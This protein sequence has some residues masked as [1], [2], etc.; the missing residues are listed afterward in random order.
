MNNPIKIIY[1]VKNLQNEYQYNNYIYIGKIDNNI[2]NILEKIKNI[3]L[4]KTL[5]ILSKT[6]YIILENY[7][8]KKWY[9]KLFN[10]KHI[11]KTIDIIN[12]TKSKY[13][14]LLSIYKNEWMN[15]HIVLNIDDNYKVMYNFTDIYNKYLEKKL[16]IKKLEEASI[17]YSI[18]KGGNIKEIITDIVEEVDTDENI[19][20]DTNK[21]ILIE[22]DN[23]LDTV[24]DIDNEFS[25]DEL[26]KMNKDVES[27]DKNLKQ[28]TKIINNI[29]D[30]KHVKTNL[31]PFDTSK[32]E[33][34]YEIKLE[35]VFNKIYVYDQYL[36]YDDTIDVIKKK[37]TCSIG[38]NPIFYNNKTYP[39]LPSNI[40][41]YSVYSHIHPNNKKLL[42]DSIMIGQ[43]WIK[44]T[45]VLSIDVVPEK[46]IRRYEQL[47]K[48]LVLLKEDIKRYGSK[49][50]RED[51]ST[52][53]LRY[54]NE[55]IN[56]NEIYMLDIFNELGKNFVVTQDN[57]QNIIDVYVKIYFFNINKE[58][59]NNI[60]LFINNNNPNN[61]EF[62]NKL[63]LSYVNQLRLD[64]NIMNTIG[65]L[66]EKKKYD[67]YSNPN[68]ITQATIHLNIY[69]EK[70]KNNK[71]NLFRI[72][73][74][75]ELSNKY[76]FLIYQSIDGNLNYKI[77][78][79]INEKNEEKIKR[80]W[81][82]TS[83]YGI[84]FKIK[85]DDLDDKYISVNLNEFGRIE[86]KN[87]WQE[88]NKTTIDDLEKT[89]IY[90]IKVIKKI[91]NENIFIK[92]N[93]PKNK[94]FKF[95]FI[96]SIQKFK[97]SNNKIINHNQLS[98]LSRYFYPYFSLVIEPKKRQ[99]KVISE[100]IT[101]KYGTYLRYKR[102]DKFDNETKIEFKII[103]F[104]K[105]YEYTNKSL[106]ETISKIFNITIEIANRKIEEVQKK[107]PFIKK[108]RKILKSLDN[109]PKYKPPGIGID[110]QG[111][112][113]DNYKIRINGA[114]DKEQL[115]RINNIVNILIY[116]YNEI[117]ILKNEKYIETIKSKL[118]SYSN[119][120]NRLNKVIDIVPYLSKI[121]DVKN[122]I[123]LDKER[124]GFK[125]EKGQ[126]QWTRSC[127]NSGEN[128]KRRP[129]Q[130]NSN[131]IA[132]M[133]KDGYKLN[134]KNGYYEK[135]VK[136]QNKTITLKAVKIPNFDG[137]GNNIYYSCDPKKNK[138]HYYI[139]FLARSS[140]P[141]GHC[142]PC[143]F[144]KDQF[145]SKNKE[146]KNYYLECIG[147]GK[148]EKEKVEK[149]EYQV[150]KLY[151]IQESNKI[152]EGRFGYLPKVLNI[153]FNI[154]QQNKKVVSNNYL[155]ES[156][157][158]YYFKYGTNQIN[159][160]FLIAI[161]NLF[162]LTLSELIE[163]IIK[164][165][166][167][168]KNLLVFKSL[169]NGDI[170]IMFKNINDYIGYI[171]NNNYISY[172]L[173]IDLLCSENILSEEGINIFIFERI[174]KNIKINGT[175][176]IK[177]DYTINCN[178]IEN[179]KSY[180]K[181]N[182]K[183]YLLIK[184]NKN[185]Y[186]IKLVKIIKSKIEI[187]NNFIYDE[188]KNN[189]INKIFKYYKLNCL[190][191]NIILKNLNYDYNSKNIFNN[192]I[193]INNLK[194]IYQ[195]LDNLNKC[196]YFILNNN[197]ILLIEKLSGS[198]N[199]IPI[200]KKLDKYKKSLN[201]SLENY[202]L[203]NK[204]L[205]ID[206]MPKYLY[207][208]EIQNKKYNIIG[209][210]IFLQENNI[211]EIIEE[212]LTRDSINKLINKLGIKKI[213]LKK[214]KKI[215]ELEE[216]L[217]SK[218]KDI[219]YDDRIKDTI[220]RNYNEESYNIFKLEI[221]EY[222][223]NNNNIK[224]KIKDFI[225][226]KSKKIIL[227]IKK[228][229]YDIIKKLYI[230]K[231]NSNKLTYNKLNN[232]RNICSNYSKNN[233]SNNIF[234]DYN[235][236]KCKPILKKDLLY[237][238]ISK[239]SNELVYNTIIYNEVLNIDNYYISTIINTNIYQEKENQKIIKTSNI[240]N[241]N[242]IL[243]TIFKDNNLPKLTKTNKY[244]VEIE[245][246][247][248]Y[249]LEKFNKYYLQEIIS[250]SNSIYRAVINAYYWIGNNLYNIEDKNLGYYSKIQTSLTNYFKGL[251]INWLLD[252]KNKDIYDKNLKSY[253][254][255]DYDNIYS[256]IYNISSI[257]NTTSDNIVTLFILNQ[258]I[259][260]PIII[261]NN[262]FKIIY[263]FDSEIKNVNGDN[264]K[265]YN[266]NKDY[267]SV[268]YEYSDRTYPN[269][270][271]TIHFI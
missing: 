45:S 137:K 148:K 182:K 111:K 202:I 162:K 186:P 114:R 221:S 222:L 135:I 158:G 255:I 16:K 195:Y 251:V 190:S 253:L 31:I 21:E 26:D 232:Y 257:E 167:K 108:S 53:T 242:Q 231:D 219:I 80:N 11:N 268:L 164:K 188:N 32:N 109:I 116:I 35:D 37:I 224:D 81:F 83:P 127:Q 154:L 191:N 267:I 122:M 223:N 236:G 12:Q 177:I 38:L 105:N 193:K 23:L 42:N 52:N 247:D 133:I 235:N 181:K 168:D 269:I 113:I 228:I 163:I 241:I 238:F 153:F 30:I 151:I 101:S 160:N 13:N 246:L 142:M 64:N 94:D 140:N 131:N 213:E 20:E 187:I 46:N 47:Y 86:Y 200:I 104:M 237:N 220:I 254:N 34:H 56:N 39:I 244:D 51:D 174:E 95:A 78:S 217:I 40:Y 112:D 176:K 239:L 150:N 87:T 240:I 97:I 259:K 233:C 201:S 212:K 185:F 126:N 263:I 77:Y 146:K 260:I 265:K 152:H 2:K 18:K 230:I 207:Y 100:N 139:G 172:N 3:N 76:P 250:N 84:S 196:I 79:N 63:Y 256:Y 144:K 166:Q 22:A 262:L 270:I 93:K 43:K 198:I 14:E 24:T 203:I 70:S 199:T 72:F 103:N 243:K 206:Y 67:I 215:K 59:L 54:Y 245:N 48:N 44:K 128:K 107:Y 165:L 61:L 261:Y 227:E 117:Y 102:I 121:E 159:N 170:S 271:K 99:A 68:Y 118:N 252:I 183:N 57:L 194:P 17:N 205:D 4:Y 210:S 189:I 175:D 88:I 161:A 28:N 89:Y 226:S 192:L 156:I 15:E 25:L 124:I 138:E 115:I 178:N 92:L 225:K 29:L 91:N 65:K 123:K 145:V 169:N 184:D 216:L 209:F 130:Y 85:V 266:E 134:K 10:S 50:K 249:Q 120:A 55:Y 27:Y 9:Y 41:L 234:C 141:Y 264:I 69:D 149:K 197:S 75:F 136:I 7:Y 8:G 171:K 129:D 204:S 73:D 119:I 155:E 19:N 58:E 173:I 147:E 211:L 125:P 208:D 143:C 49:I 74:N 33:I 132:K 5:T 6:D 179:F 180:Y 82:E 62:N 248:G 258:I 36:Y 66:I 98:E 157:T 71:I 90:I 110:I 60:I 96:N 106:A 218:N 229:L 214:L 1:K